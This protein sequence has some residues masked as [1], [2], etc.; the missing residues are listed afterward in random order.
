[1]KLELSA[2]E[3]QELESSAEEET[4]EFVVKVKMENNALLEAAK[5]LIK[6]LAENYHPHIKAIVT[7]TEVEILEGLAINGTEEFLVD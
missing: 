7:S 1:M 2:E 4:R 6:Y 3:I 5:P